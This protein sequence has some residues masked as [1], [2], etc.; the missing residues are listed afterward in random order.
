[1]LQAFPPTPS[2]SPPTLTPAYPGKIPVGCPVCLLPWLPGANLGV[3]KMIHLQTEVGW[4]LCSIM[5]MACCD[6]IS[7][8]AE[9]QIIPLAAKMN[10]QSEVCWGLCSSMLMASGRCHQAVLLLSSHPLGA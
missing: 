4:A 2:P 5:L 3:A 1:M 7:T 8:S 6:A 10:A 9:L